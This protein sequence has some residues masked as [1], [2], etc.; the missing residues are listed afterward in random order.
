MSEEQNRGQNKLEQYLNAEKEDLARYA[1]CMF[2]YVLVF[3]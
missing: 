1:I 3:T 2:N